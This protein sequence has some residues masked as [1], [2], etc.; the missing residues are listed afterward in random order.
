MPL[1]H[2]KSRVHVWSNWVL[3]HAKFLYMMSWNWHSKSKTHSSPGRMPQCHHRNAPP[4]LPQ[5]EMA[6]SVRSPL[7]PLV[8]HRHETYSE[9]IMSCQKARKTRFWSKLTGLTGLVSLVKSLQLVWSNLS[10]IQGPDCFMR[11][12]QS[13]SRA[14]SVQQ[15]SFK[16]AWVKIR[17]PNHQMVNT[18]HILTLVVL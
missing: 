2:I 17:C 6:H 1:E 15:S 14:C 7:M 13:L 9:Q 11:T 10:H 18:K 8:H 12:A 4:N 16:W 5:A 3:G